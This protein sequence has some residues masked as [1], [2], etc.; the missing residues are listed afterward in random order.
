VREVLIVGGGTAGWMAACLM[1]RAWCQVGVKIK[2][3]ESPDIGIIGVGEG[4]TPQLKMFFDALGI[5]EADWM[6]AC[7]ATYKLGIRFNHWSSDPAYSS[8]FHPFPADL[9]ADTAKPFLLTAYERRQGLPLAVHP[10]EWFLNSALAAAGLSP[11]NSELSGYQYGYHFDAYK[12]GQYLSAFAAKLGVEHISAKVVS[13][14]QYENGNLA[15][16]QLDDGREIA[17]DFFIDSTGFDGL[18]IQKTLNS[19]FISFA[20]NLFNDSAVV[21]PTPLGD[22]VAAQTDATAMSCGWRWQIPLTTRYGNGYVYSSHYLDA[23]GAENELR[24]SLDMLESEVAARHL[25]MR[26]GQLQQH[27]SHNCLAVGLAQGFIEPLEATAL[28][29]VQTTVELFIETVAARGLIDG[30]LGRLEEDARDQFNQTIRGRFE[31]VRDYIVCHYQVSSRDDSDYWRDNARNAVRSENL[32][33][34]MD[35]WYLRQDVTP[36][37]LARD[38]SQYYSAIS[39]HCLLAGYGVFPPADQASAAHQHEARHRA[40][41]VQQV[42]QRAVLGHC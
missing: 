22:W 15:S 30:V 24:S 31:G 17:A 4:S 37:L 33:A 40:H 16:V 3:V 23:E 20:D 35:A 9:D 1:A 41:Y 6:P 29:L 11:A 2:L 34:V 21:L 25:K 32:Q 26:V 18:L 10:D 36:V 19:P 8:Y 7:D 13:V 12:V 27:W 42:I 38:M 5:A 28:H 39:W 14:N